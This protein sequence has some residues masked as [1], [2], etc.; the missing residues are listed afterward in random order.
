MKKYLSLIITGAILLSGCGTAEPVFVAEKENPRITTAA[1]IV[2]TTVQTP[3]R[4]P[5]TMTATA[6]QETAT[7]AP[8][9]STSSRNVLKTE[10]VTVLQVQSE[11]ASETTATAILTEII[12]PETEIISDVKTTLTAEVIQPSEAT[13]TQPVTT[14]TTSATTT[15]QSITTTT[16]IITQTEPVR[17]LTEEEK[18]MERGRELS[19]DGSEFG[20]AQA[21]FSLMQNI[22]HGTCVNFAYQTMYICKGVG[23]ECLYAQ[24]DAGLGGHFANI[25]KISGVWYVF[26][27]QGGCFLTTNIC[28]FTQILDEYQNYISDASI[29]SNTNFVG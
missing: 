12:T 27:T 18:L 19:H 15:T 23:L 7:E 8:E 20:K 28:G 14:S 1:E 3:K 22:G 24:T 6:V 11:T 16:E 4:K 2:T 26:D 17:E 5:E 9:F 29:I 21:V 25:V 13:E 10:S